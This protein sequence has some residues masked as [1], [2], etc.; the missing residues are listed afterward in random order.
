MSDST[1][2]CAV[3]PRSGFGRSWGA[4][5][6]LTRVRDAACL[7]IPAKQHSTGEMMDYSNLKNVVDA[8]IYVVDP[9]IVLQPHPETFGCALRVHGWGR[10]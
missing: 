5:V 2:G 3:W 9:A 10:L 7:S 8:T 6:K 1:K 4:T